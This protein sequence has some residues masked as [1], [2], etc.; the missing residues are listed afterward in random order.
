MTDA[1]LRRWVVP[2]AALTS[3]AVPLLL[4]ACFDLEGWG[5]FEDC[6]DCAQCR[7]LWIRQPAPEEGP[8]P[9]PTLPEEEEATGYTTGQ[10]PLEDTGPG[11]SGEAPPADESE[12][13]EPPE[14][15]FRPRIPDGVLQP[16]PDPNLPRPSP[17][18]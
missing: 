18:Y 9:P 15:P 5:W 17:T 12:A 1:R 2:G 8:L 7:E 13:E 11:P 14:Q 4:G 3:I 10:A 6:D 16:R